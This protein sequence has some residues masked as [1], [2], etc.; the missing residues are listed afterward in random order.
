MVNQSLNIL[1]EGGQL[2]NHKAD[3]YLPWSCH[4]REDGGAK[5][6][7]IQ[8]G[9]SWTMKFC[10]FIFLR[11]EAK[12]WRSH[13]K[14]NKHKIGNLIFIRKER[15]ALEI[16]CHEILLLLMKIKLI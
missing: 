6:K 1:I 13:R 7:L 12:Q 3:V 11:K 5:G 8:E 9:Y 16:L 10:P 14:N 4:V 2:G 15:F